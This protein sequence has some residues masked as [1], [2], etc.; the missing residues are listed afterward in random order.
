[1][2]LGGLEDSFLPHSQMTRRQEAT[3]PTRIYKLERLQF[4]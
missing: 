3:P 2:D 4:E 1:M